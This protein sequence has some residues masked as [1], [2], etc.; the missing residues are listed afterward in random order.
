MPYDKGLVQRIAGALD[1]MYA[2]VRQKDMFG[3]RGFLMGKATF[4]VAWDNDLI[5][6]SPPREYERLLQRPGVAAFS[7]DGEVPMSTWVVVAAD[8]IAKEPELTEWLRKG[9]ETVPLKQR[10]PSKG[11]SIVR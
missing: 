8:V 10:T 9:I 11:I 5:V 4:A 2:D 1:H 6:K 7:P 3:G